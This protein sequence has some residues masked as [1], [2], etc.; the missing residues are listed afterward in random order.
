[1]KI[2]FSDWVE[3]YVD[4]VRLYLKSV[5]FRINDNTT[6]IECTAVETA[7]EILCAVIQVI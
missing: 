4:D 5:K 3:G 2:Y 6:T 1:M 7:N